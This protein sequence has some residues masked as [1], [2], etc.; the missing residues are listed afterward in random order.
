MTV[1]QKRTSVTY[2]NSKDITETIDAYNAS[3][4]EYISVTCIL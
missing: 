1:M 4:Y 3:T 2:P